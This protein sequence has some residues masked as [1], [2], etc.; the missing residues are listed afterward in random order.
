MANCRPVPVRL[1]RPPLAVFL[2]ATAGSGPTT[3]NLLKH[4]AHLDSFVE[5]TVHHADQMVKRQALE[6]P[7]YPVLVD[8][9]GPRTGAVT[10]YESGGSFL[11]RNGGTFIACDGGENGIVRRRPPT[12]Y[13]NQPLTVKLIRPI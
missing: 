13:D 8:G 4:W 7:P 6:Y 12:K 5:E 2:A 1:H 3:K 10:L 11:K 9:L